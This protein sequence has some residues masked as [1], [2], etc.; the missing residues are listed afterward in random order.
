VSEK[1]QIRPFTEAKSE[2]PKGHA[3]WKYINAGSALEVSF[4]DFL[5]PAQ[6]FNNIENLEARD[7]Q[8]ILYLNKVS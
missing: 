7:Y 5:L 6:N 2:F 1:K 4:A 3:S 8:I